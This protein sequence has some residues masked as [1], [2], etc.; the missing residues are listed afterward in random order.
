MNQNVFSVGDFN[1][2]VDDGNDSS[3]NKFLDLLK[4]YDFKQHAESATH[5]EGHTQGLHYRKCNAPGPQHKGATR[6][7]IINF[8][9][10]L[11]MCIFL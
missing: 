9:Q 5:V 1:L 2:H 3:V 11:Q 7:R 4:V 8:L 6:Y 10:N